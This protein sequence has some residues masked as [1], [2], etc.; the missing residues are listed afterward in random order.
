MP[1]NLTAT[2]SPR[3]SKSG[4]GKRRYAW[5]RYMDLI[6]LP[7]AGMTPSPAM[8]PYRNAFL[9]GAPSGG[10]VTNDSGDLSGN[11]PWLTTVTDSFSL[12]TSSIVPPRP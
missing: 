2:L 6:P 9:R 3:M 1:E 12:S 7:D 4:I 11:V 5:D 10:P 8:A